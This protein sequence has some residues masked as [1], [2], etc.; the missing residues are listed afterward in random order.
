MAGQAKWYVIH[1]YSGYEKKVETNIWKLIENRNLQ[2]VIFDIRVPEE[3]DSEEK[4]DK[5]G[6]IVKAFPG[7]VFIK[8]IMSDDSWHAVRSIRGVTG[9]VG[10]ES[11]PVPLTEEELINI[12]IEKKVANADFEIG[13]IVKILEGPLA[14]YTGR[15]IELVPEQ[16][17]VK[18]M[19]DLFMGRETE[20]DLEIDQVE[21]LD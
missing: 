10:P 21:P 11:K 6:A 4:S 2:D 13:D 5:K 14:G 17:K 18:M 3:E 19:V 9:F 1:T 7:Y 12:K 8:M 16:N 20:V 15:V